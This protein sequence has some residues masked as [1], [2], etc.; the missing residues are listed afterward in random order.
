M[1]AE[2]RTSYFTFGQSHA[3]AVNGFTFD[4][5]VVVKITAPD[6]RSVMCEHFGAKWAFEYDQCPDMGHF[7]RGIKELP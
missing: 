4:K 6:P 7:P 3:H 5:D 1:S 2:L